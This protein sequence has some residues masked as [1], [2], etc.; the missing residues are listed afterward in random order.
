MNVITPWMSPKVEVETSALH[1]RGI[2][3]LSTIA[4]GEPILVWGGP[5][6]TDKAG[7]LEALRRKKSVMQWDDDIFSYE[8]DGDEND[9]EPFMINHSCDPNAWM[10]G[11]HTICARRNI[12]PGEEITADYALW[13]ADEGH[14]SAWVCHC[15]TSLCRGRVTG[16]DWKDPGLRERYRGHFSPLLNKHIEQRRKLKAGDFR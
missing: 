3:A 11:A 5:G 14:V 8:V 12:A 16:V 10:N 13:E 7:A 6:Y 4:C 2:I 9:G 15:G 1:G